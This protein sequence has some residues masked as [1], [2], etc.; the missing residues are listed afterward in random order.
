MTMSATRDQLQE[1]FRD[2]FDDE[3]IVLT[4]ST[5]AKDVA[6]WDSLKNVRLIVQIEK[7]FKIRFG[8]GEVVGLNNVGE[9]LALIDKKRGG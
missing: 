5:S 3:S 6:G 2:L 8:T 1:I 4:D 7:A 9:L